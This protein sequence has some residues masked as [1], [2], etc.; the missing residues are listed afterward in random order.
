M[1]S[2]L[3]LSDLDDSVSRNRDS[4]LAIQPKPEGNDF[5]AE[6]M[7]TNHKIDA[8]L[9]DVHFLCAK[10]HIYAKNSGISD[11]KFERKAS[12]PRPVKVIHPKL[13]T[14]SAYFSSTP[15]KERRRPV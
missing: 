1:D 13:D 11:D 8:I 3:H 10:A 15:K 6:F 4:E 9:A 5:D 12:T 7:A 14:E 2:S